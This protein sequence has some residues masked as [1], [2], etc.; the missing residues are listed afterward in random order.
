MKPKK[1]KKI[2][3]KQKKGKG[4]EF[5]GRKKSPKSTTRQGEGGWEDIKLIDA[6]AGAVCS[7]LPWDR[8]FSFNI[9]HLVVSGSSCDSCSCS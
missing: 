9:R 4:D 5:E 2:K 7:F 1:E 3:E 8:L 6:H